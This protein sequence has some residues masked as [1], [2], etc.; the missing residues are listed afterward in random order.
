[1]SGIA[2]TVLGGLADRVVP[3]IQTPVEDIIYEVLDQKGLPTRAEVRDLRGRIDKL[4]KVLTDLKATLEGLRADLNTAVA[5]RPVVVAA[6][7]S[8]APSS[9]ASAS[10]PAPAIASVEPPPVEASG[11]TAEAASSVKSCRV[12]GCEGALRAKGFCAKHYQQWKR[13]TLEGFVAPDGT[14]VHGAVR[15][16]VEAAAQGQ[17]VETRYEG[18]E[19][20]FFLPETGRTLRLHG[21]TARVDE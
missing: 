2:N 8:A 12:D 5:T 3:L 10:P 19:V 13:L 4:E 11:D 17:V 20:I 21:A 9:P 14:T 16:R 18:D 6:A 15:Y 1:M 7:P